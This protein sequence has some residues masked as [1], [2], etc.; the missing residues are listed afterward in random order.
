MDG[1]YS[2]SW[3]IMMVNDGNASNVYSWELENHHSLLGKST[4]SIAIFNSKLSVTRALILN[5]EN[6]DIQSVWG[7]PFSDKPIS[8]SIKSAEIMYCMCTLHIQTIFMYCILW[9]VAEILHQLKTVVNI[10]W[11]LGFNHPKL[12]VYRI[13][14]AHPFRISIFSLWEPCQIPP[15]SRPG[16]T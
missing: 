2:I 12:V 15:G 5:G 7:T 11:Y 8:E 13:S 16:G 3:F 9:M 10:P 6:D 1:E 4:I 14:L